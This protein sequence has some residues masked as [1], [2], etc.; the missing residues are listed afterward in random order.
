M[1]K[2]LLISSVICLIAAGSQAVMAH[3]DEGCSNLPPE[4]KQ[5]LHK[6]MEDAH[7]QNLPLITREHALHGE[8]RAILTAPEFDREKFDAKV[9]E[10][11]EVSEQIHATRH[12]A[13]A[14]SAEHMTQEERKELA[15]HLDEKGW[16]HHGMHHHGAG[17]MQGTAV[18]SNAPDSSK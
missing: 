11:T 7:Q 4:K 3:G 2:V 5:M 6:A 14:D 10:M 17:H 13:F 18:K 1:K 12:K 16:H 9:H 15:R 8:L